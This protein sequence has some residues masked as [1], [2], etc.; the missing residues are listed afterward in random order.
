MM[1]P[2]PTIVLHCYWLSYHLFIF[3]IYCLCRDRSE[4]RLCSFSWCP[5]FMQEHLGNHEWMMHLCPSAWILMFMRHVFMW[6]SW[7]WDAY[8][9]YDNLKPDTSFGLRH[10]MVYTWAYLDWSMHLQ[11]LFHYFIIY[12]LE[13]SSL[14]VSL[15]LCMIL[16]WWWFFVSYEYIC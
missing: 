2:L 14:L 10:Y 12:F 13:Q 8:L 5:A 4:I 6:M 9:N 11:I 3:S 16:Q 1:S 15:K 7:N